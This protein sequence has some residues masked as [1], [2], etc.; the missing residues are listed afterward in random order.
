MKGEG[1]SISIIIPT[2]DEAD[3]IEPLLAR[4]VRA[5]GERPAEVIFA[6]D[7]SDDTPQV[8]AS[9]AAAAPIRV[10][11]L[12]R[13]RG[14]RTGGLGGAVVAGLRASTG[15]IAVVMDGDL[16]HP[17]ECVPLLLG[18]LDSQDVDVV[19]ASRYSHGGRAEGLS[20][21]T[22]RTISRG[23]TVVARV[24]FPLRLRQ[25]SDPMSGFFAVRLAG[26]DIDRLHPIGYKILLEVVL[27]NANLRVSEVGFEFGA[28]HSGTSKA[29]VREGGRFLA[30]VVRLRLATIVAPRRDWADREDGVGTRDLL[31]VEPSV[32]PRAGA[33]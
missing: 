14:E 31:G 26:C 9:A 2:K 10:V 12:H 7:S 24:F 8:I 3:C 27:R 23:L 4:L 32:Q 22:R 11:C 29:G 15:Q 18:V 13:R 19:V 33:A 16:Q 17:P 30:H 6:D 1:N 21:Q 5:L 25:V 20:N 28:R